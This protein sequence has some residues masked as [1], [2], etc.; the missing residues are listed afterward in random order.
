M[1]VLS[2]YLL[3][4]IASYFSSSNTNIMSTT[5]WRSNK[6]MNKFN[7]FNYVPIWFL[8]ITK[9]NL[10]WSRSRVCTNVYP[11]SERLGSGL[12]GFSLCPLCGVFNCWVK[13]RLSWSETHWNFAVDKLRQETQPLPCFAVA[14]V[15]INTL[16]GSKRQHHFEYTQ[17]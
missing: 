13:S 7:L 5:W 3:K 2:L 10:L 11:Y 15:T 17:V 16:G 9:I 14:T 8:S 6:S 1:A 12:K 4:Q